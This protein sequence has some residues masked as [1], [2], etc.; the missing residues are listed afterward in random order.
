MADEAPAAAI[1]LKNDEALVL[2]GFATQ[3]LNTKYAELRLHPAERTVLEGLLITLE[4]TLTEPFLETYQELLEQA[5][6]AVA[7][8]QPSDDAEDDDEF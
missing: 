5:R 8:R 4:D 7:A 2:F 1:K 3:F 6:A